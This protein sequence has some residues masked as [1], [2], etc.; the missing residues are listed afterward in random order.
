MEL[1]EMVRQSWPLRIRP[2][3]IIRISSVSPK[4]VLVCVHQSRRKDATVLC[5]CWLLGSASMLMTSVFFSSLLLIAHLFRKITLL[6]SD[7]H[8]K[9]YCI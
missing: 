9:V 2:T 4:G 8:V 7:L 1:G 6:F 3:G 5:S